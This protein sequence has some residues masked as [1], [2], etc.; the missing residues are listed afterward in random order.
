MFYP[1]YDNNFI[2][3]FDL[4]IGIM[5]IAFTEEII[6]RSYYLFV[7]R[8]RIK[9]KILIILVSCIV[10]GLSHWSLGLHSIITT[11]IWGI[12]SMIS[13]IITKSIW[14]AIIAHYLTDFVAFSEIIPKEWFDFII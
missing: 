10:F 6:F 5:L 8:E 14:P 13:L 12:M 4:T 1:S 11:A 7:L 3:I 9:S 2:K